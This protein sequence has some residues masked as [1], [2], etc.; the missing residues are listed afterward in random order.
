MKHADKRFIAVWRLSGRNQVPLPIMN[1]TT[2]KII[3]PANLGISLKKDAK[4]IV[5]TFPKKYM[6]VMIEISN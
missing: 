5:V 3:Y 2:A 4:G 6:A 1:A